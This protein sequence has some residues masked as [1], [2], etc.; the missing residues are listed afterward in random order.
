MALSQAT[1]PGGVENLSPCLLRLSRTDAT[2]ASAFCWNAEPRSRP[3]KSA[4]F[5]VAVFLVWFHPNCIAVRLVCTAAERFCTVMSQ[6]FASGQD[7]E[8]VRNELHELSR[9]V[10][11]IS[12]SQP[13]SPK[14]AKTHPQ[15]QASLPTGSAGLR[16][17][18]STDTEDDILGIAAP[19]RGST[20]MS[21]QERLQAVEILRSTAAEHVHTVTTILDRYNRST[22][23]TLSNR[24]QV[25]W[26]RLRHDFLLLRRQLDSVS[27]SAISA[28]RAH[29][30]RDRESTT[31]TPNASAEEDAT[32]GEESESQLH[33]RLLPPATA[34]AAAGR[35]MDLD[36]I[37]AAQDATLR[38][39]EY[40]SLAKE[41]QDLNELY[42]DLSQYVSS[43][44]EQMELAST[45]IQDADRNVY[46][47]TEE[48]RKAAKLQTKLA[49]VVGAG[50]GALIGGPVGL[51]AGAKLGLIVGG[52]CAGVG[53][54]VGGGVRRMQ[55]RVVERN[56]PS[57][58]NEK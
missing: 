7:A 56:Q 52:V 53:A 20:A 49:P 51:L 28:A 46:R 9:I 8:V 35:G 37:L 15:G 58:P 21:P 55:G 16:S 34:T 1:V 39:E 12:N 36:A 14:K 5:R 25:L 40:A 19:E 54:V 2:A 57:R 38:S 41:M 44:G 3:T 50:L 13:P 4:I 6:T 29:L 11:K 10:F 47:G 42:G 30:Q 22:T 33:R 27:A 23:Q 32:D 48:T 43:Q 26:Q 45:D 31:D 17:N 18:G 24:E